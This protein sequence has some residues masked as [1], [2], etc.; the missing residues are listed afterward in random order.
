MAM[1]NNELGA[2]V[3]EI[4]GQRFEEDEVEG[5]NRFGPY[6]ARRVWTYDGTQYHA[7]YAVERGEKLQ[8][9]EDFPPFANWLA[10]EFSL[11]DRIGQTERMI[12]IGV[13]T[14]VVLVALGLLVYLIVYA[15]DQASVIKYLLA[16]IVGAAASYVFLRKAPKIPTG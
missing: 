1:T 3:A 13:A 2:K 11:E 4:Y 12:R 14:V 16:A 8:T 15:P 7:H 5:P 6:I 9:F 10:D